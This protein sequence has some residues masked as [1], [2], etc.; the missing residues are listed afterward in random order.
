MTITKQTHKRNQEAHKVYVSLGFHVNFYHSWRGDTPDEAG[1]G[2]DIRVIGE[3]LRMLDKANEAGLEA[4][5]Y[6]DFDGYWTLQEILPTYAPDIIEKVARRVQVGLDDIVLGSYNN[7]ANYAATERE[8]RITN[9]YALENPY[10]SGVKQLFG[11]TPKVL[12]PQ[13][14]MYTV[15]QNAILKSQGI[16]GIVLYYAH[17]PFNT[18][19]AFIPSLSP[20]DRYNPLL[21]RMTEEEEPIVVFP[22]ICPSDVIDNVSLDHMLLD[23]RERQLSGEINS[24]VLVHINFDADAEYWLPVHVPKFLDWFPNIGGLEEYIKVVNQ[25]SWAAFTTPERYL[26]T[27]PPMKEILVRQDLADGGFDGSYS[28]AE[29]YSTQKL[30][31]QLEQSRWKTYQAE[32]LIK[33]LPEKDQDKFRIDLWDGDNSSFFKRMIGLTTTHFGMSTPVVNEQREARAEALL[34][35]ANQQA[36]ELVH[37]AAKLKQDRG[38]ERLDVLYD[39]EVFAPDVPWE[40]DKT[41]SLFVAKVPVI[42][43][44]DVRGVLLKGEDE[45]EIPVSIIDVEQMSDGRLGGTLLFLTELAS[46]ESKRFYLV[47]GVDEQTKPEKIDLLENE[48]ILM[49][50]SENAGI[51]R[52]EID[53]ER[54]GGEDFLQPFITYRQ[55][56]KLTV[57]KNTA[58][59]VSCPDDFQWHGIKRVLLSANIPIETDEGTVNSELKYTFT[60]FDALPFVLVD[61][62]VDYAFTPPR[63]VI[64]NVQQKLRR[65]L[66]E[67]WIEVAPFQVHPNIESR[68]DDYLRVWKHNYLGITSYYDLDYREINFENRALDSFNH[69]V[70]A[71]WTAVSDKEKGLLI[72]QSAERLTS[73]AFCPMRLDGTDGK[74]QIWLNPFGSYFGKQ[75]NYAHMGGNGV[76]AVVTEVLSGA[77]KPNGPSFNGKYVQYSLLLA[78]YV[79][80]CP[81]SDLQRAAMNHFYLPGIFYHRALDFEHVVLGE[82]LEAMMAADLKLQQM[83]SKE[84]LPVPAALIAN[85][86]TENADVVWEPIQDVRVSGF[87]VRWKDAG[88]S[89]EKSVKIRVD[90]RYQIENLVDGEKYFIRVRSLKGDSAS[91][92]SRTVTCVP[93]AVPVVSVLKALKGLSLATIWKFVSA[94]IWHVLSAPARR[95]K[96]ERK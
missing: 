92:W 83:N 90:N 37:Q 65:L 4:F 20:G 29:K 95:R 79:G 15:G 7:G 91:L 58:Y 40:S 38:N 5:G 78:P 45:K 62:V 68:E 82:D 84:P 63:D 59:Q 54:I 18:L 87:E 1:F 42:L 10:G 64:Q 8:F 13:E 19:G 51:E 69:Q 49:Q 28:W 11:V 50:F 60:L 34:V 43:P 39:F 73:M 75:S 94:S 71:G 25:Y 81:S 6:W 85:P 56:K 89:D 21:M 46:D 47:E 44:N 52:V 12:R 33:K 61:V 2:T 55:G 26:E 77:L 16:E 57:C 93:G 70:T 24:D 36:Y 30:W 74:Q 14:C 76:G 3:I 53:G 23:L 17:T 80:D 86:S 32:A 72:G 9:T 27:N 31:S 66:D 22:A 48:R 41:H 88:S 67:N 96:L 35:D